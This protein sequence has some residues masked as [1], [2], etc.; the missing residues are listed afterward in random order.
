MAQSHM[1]CQGLTWASSFLHLHFVSWRLR[2][3]PQFLF[4]GKRDDG[5]RLL[6][7]LSVSPLTE[8]T[9]HSFLYLLLGSYEQLRIAVNGSYGIRQ[10]VRIIL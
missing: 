5:E 8:F 4:I 2:I 7:L 6:D 9:H 1:P 3:P 10:H